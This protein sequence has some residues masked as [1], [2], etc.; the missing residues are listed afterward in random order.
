VVYV[1]EGYSAEEQY[2]PQ[3]TEPPHRLH[4]RI[5]ITN[6]DDDP[7]LD[8]R[9]WLYL[10]WV[11]WTGDDA[12]GQPLVPGTYTLRV[13]V[14][15]PVGNTRT[16][17]RPVQVAGA[18]LSQRSWVETV[19]A[20]SVGDGSAPVSDP[21]CLGCGDVCAPVLSDRF[22]GGLSFRQPCDFGYAAL[23]YFGAAPPFTPAPVDYYRVSATGGPMTPGDSDVGWLDGVAMGPGDV[24]VTSPYHSVDPT[25]VPYLPSG[26]QPLN[27]SFQ[28]T[29]E[30]DYDVASFTVEYRYYV[31][32]G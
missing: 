28:T 5:T 3:Y 18:Q 16:F 23:Q 14:R 21:S 29:S 20:G 9:F 27:W 17:R 15:D 25:T 4:T 19:A 30:N 32:V 7:V 11:K 6:A 26:R 2:Y 24:T 8:Q 12:E 22:P 31:P 13:S 1:R 10:P